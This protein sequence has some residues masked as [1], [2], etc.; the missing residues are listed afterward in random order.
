MADQ[1]RPLADEEYG[2]TDL[3]VKPTL[4]LINP[5]IYDFA[6]YDLW[7][8]PLGLLYLGGYLRASGFD[9]H[10]IDCMDVHHP[11]AA[12]ASSP[13]PPLRTPFG[14]GKFR[15]E[16]VQKPPI[17]KGIR[18]FY[19]RYGIPQ[20]RFIHDLARVKK[21]A[22]V[23]ITSL[24]TYWYPGVK[25]VISICRVLHPDTPIL[26]GGIYAGLCENHASTSGA[27]RV[28]TG[29]SLKHMGGLL[30]ILKEY[31]IEPEN[32]KAP[33]RTTPFPSFDLLHGID[34][35]A[36]L[37]STG[38]PYRCE[39]CACSFLNPAFTRRN[40]EEIVEEILYW[41]KQFGV[42]DFAFYD[43]ALLI[44]FENHA[45]LFLEKLASIQPDLRFHTPN[46]LHV[47]AITPEV[48][49]LLRKAGFRTIRL[50]LETAD[51]ALHQCLDRKVSEGDF[52]RAVA[53]LLRKGFDRRD[54]G[55]YILAGL[56]DQSI[57]SVLET[58][59]F[60]AAVGAS[61]Y[62]A[63]YS[64]L[65]HTPLWEKAVARSDY[66]LPSEPLFHNN[67]LLPCWEEQKRLRFTE[68][69]RRVQALREI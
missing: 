9:I 16:I 32:E 65:P 14:T 3:L 25:E 55:A 7:A 10:L 20:Q 69:K 34:S 18:R 59:E 50:G 35:I 13:P 19:S 24:M 21:P 39:Y 4:I 28:V 40:P 68:V 1:R 42:Q 56:P 57:E 37:T 23:L 66:D 53:S 62:L 48:A 41:H 49:D 26:M 47:N 58:V 12:A 15:R 36:L 27:D 38:C 5:W 6:A 29:F 22:A 54:I 51:M 31:E 44:D 8:K 46:A 67:T 2:I 60:A 45:G 43:D 64:P 30:D 17:F 61:P 11:G 33:L 52:E 63:E